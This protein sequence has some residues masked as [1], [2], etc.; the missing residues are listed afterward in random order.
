MNGRFRIGLAV[1]SA[2]LLLLPL[3]AFFAFTWMKTLQ[4]TSRVQAPRVI[5]MLHPVE[6]EGTLTYGRECQS[7]RDCDPRL[8]CFFS[9]VMQS[10]YCVDSGCMTD[11][12]CPNDF[13]CQT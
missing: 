5:P 7:D 12:H 9:M 2:L 13:S 11:K 6:R 10:S 8:R 4:D 3:L 1:L